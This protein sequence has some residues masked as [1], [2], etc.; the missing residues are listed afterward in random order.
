MSFENIKQLAQGK[1][2]ITINNV[3]EE[4]NLL[5]VSERE[6][7]DSLT[8]EGF[9]TIQ[10]NLGRGNQTQ[11]A[12]MNIQ[13]VTEAHNRADHYLIKCSFKTDDKE[14]TEE[15]INGLYDIYPLLVKELKRV[16][17]IIDTDD[18]KVIEA[19]QEKTEQD[20]KN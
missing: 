3:T 14:I 20:L 17:G 5:T 16:N 2:T 10:A 15:D 9:G 18:E 7:Y 12:N 13:K 11:K 4:V 1:A 19:L 8:N 6:R